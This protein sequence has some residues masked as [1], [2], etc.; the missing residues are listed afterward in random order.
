M[1]DSKRVQ[2]IE[3]KYTFTN[4]SLS[5][6][7]DEIDMRL[8]GAD[9]WVTITRTSGLISK[10]EYFKDAAKTMKVCEQVITRATGVGGVKLVSNIQNIYYNSDTSED[11]QVNASLSRPSLGTDDDI[12]ACSSVFSTTEDT[13]C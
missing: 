6:I 7:I 2:S 9:C 12:T 13:G 5:G 8:N 11:S 3:G 4:R 1:V 10:V